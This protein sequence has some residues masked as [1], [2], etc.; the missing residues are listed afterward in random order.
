MKKDILRFSSPAEAGVSPRAVTAFLDDVADRG[1]AMH[2]FLFLR[3]GKV[4]AE[5]YYAPFQKDEPHRMYSVSKTFVSMAVG[6]LIGE[7]K[8]KLSDRVAS[9]FPDKCPPDL[10][11]WVA[12]PRSGT[13]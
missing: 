7:G 3:H 5:G 11:P 9:F 4:F 12:T 6:A 13:F 10:H 1:F 8:L 2:G